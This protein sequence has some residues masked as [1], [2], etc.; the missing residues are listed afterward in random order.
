MRGMLLGIVAGLLAFCVARLYGEPP[1]DWAISYEER[2]AAA[3]SDPVSHIHD[4]GAE[5]VAPLS[6]ATQ[7]GPGLFTGMVVFGTA[8]G[9]LFALVFSL[10][11][12]RMGT[13]GPRSTAALIAL[14]GFAAVTLVPQLK[15][16]ASPPAVGAEDT[17]GWRTGLY[18]L[19]LASSLASATIAAIVA[20]KLKP[21]FGAWN[22]AVVACVGFA[23]CISVLFLVMPTVEEV[24][25]DFSAT[26][27]WNFRMASL[28][29]HAVLWAV[30]GAGFG[31]LAE[32][33]FSSDPSARRMA[34][35]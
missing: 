18:F 35:R 1:V 22:A 9:G 3:S 8:L 21:A 15:Y 6:R 26:V 10:C 33:G 5:R 16:P 13:L 4:H 31:P 14:A 17:I 28:G 11:Y 19:L 29:I 27:L 30:L 20:D 24:P 12:G 2:V 34:Q 23:I 25:D 32:G 7:S